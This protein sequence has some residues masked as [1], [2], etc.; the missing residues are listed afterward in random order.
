MPAF[1]SA[2]APRTSNNGIFDVP[3]G[4][5]SGS[6]LGMGSPLSPDVGLHV[7]KHSTGRRTEAQRAREH[8]RIRQ[9]EQT[10][11]PP[12]FQAGC[13]S[14][15]DE[16]SKRAQK[17]Q[18]QHAQEQDQDQDQGEQDQDTGSTTLTET[19]SS[20]ATP[21]ELDSE[22][23]TAL[24]TPLNIRSS[25]SGPAAETSS[26]ASPFETENHI[27][28][29]SRGNTSSLPWTPQRAPRTK[30]ITGSQTTS[31]TQDD[32]DYVY[33]D[34]TQPKLH[35]KYHSPSTPIHTAPTSG[36]VTT[37]S[38]SG[39][40]R[41]RPRS[42]KRRRRRLHPV[43]YRLFPVQDYFLAEGRYCDVYL[44]SYLPPMRP[45]SSSHFSLD[46]SHGHLHP[47]MVEVAP[48]GGTGMNG[49]TNPTH[50]FTAETA[51]AQHFPEG[52]HSP[53]PPSP[54]EWRLCAVKRLHA[55]TTSQLVGLDEAYAL[56]RLGKHPGIVQLIDI[57]D[58]MLTSPQAP[59]Q[60]PSA[61]STPGRLVSLN[62]DAS[63]EANEAA[64]QHHRK[65]EH[66]DFPGKP[67][68]HIKPD[69]HFP[70]P[71]KADSPR[72]L[73]LLELLP[74]SLGSYVNAHPQAVDLTQWL[75]WAIQLSAA[76][77]YM[78]S[79]GAIHGDI[80]LDNCLLTR[81]L[82]LK[83]CDF[84]S[85][86]WIDP[87]NLPTDGA[88]LGTP[89]YSAPELTSSPWGM[90]GGW[91][92]T[93]SLSSS[94]SGSGYGEGQQAQRGGFGLPV[95]VWAMG[96]CLYSL[97]S[98]RAPFARATSM[99]DML[100]RK[101]LFWQAEECDRMRRL[102][103][104]QGL[105][106][107]EQERLSSS[108]ASRASGR[109]AVGS[110]GWTTA[111]TSTPTRPVSASRTPSLC[112]R[113]EGEHLRTPSHHTRSP[114][115]VSS[116]SGVHAGV[117]LS[118]DQ[119]LLEH[120]TVTHGRVPRPEAVSAL[121]NPAPPPVRKPLVAACST[122]AAVSPISHGLATP[123]KDASDLAQP[124]TTPS[125]S[126]PPH[127]SGLGL[128]LG[129][130]GSGGQ[131]GSGPVQ[132]PGRAVSMRAPPGHPATRV[133]H[134]NP[135]A[136]HALGLGLGMAGVDP[137]GAGASKARS[138]G[139]SRI[140]TQ[141][142]SSGRS[143]RRNLSARAA[144]QGTAPTS[145]DAVLSPLSPESLD[146][147]SPGVLPLS[148]GWVGGPRSESQKMP[149]AIMSQVPHQRPP[150]NQ[151]HGHFNADPHPHPYRQLETREAHVL[152]SSPGDNPVDGVGQGHDGEGRG[153]E[154][155]ENGEGEHEGVPAHAAG[156]AVG[157]VATDSL[158]AYKDGMPAL[159]LPG[160]GRWPDE[161][162]DLVRSMVQVDPL[163]RPTCQQVLERLCMLR[164]RLGQT[165]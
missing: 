41:M 89:A 25:H 137:S 62:P 46:Q 21:D 158:P 43:S 51:H 86:L 163:L 151:S 139:L 66:S 71:D 49:A 77:G 128:G 162:R 160:G 90:G 39:S 161:A 119:D 148:A 121:L 75:E 31:Q 123:P 135:N 115:S 102:T 144:A 127:A 20:E 95:D 56:R 114:A 44:G 74:H 109:G 36:S 96:V 7:R 165:I 97:A 101:P 154:G 83:L 42:I 117:Y 50:L 22:P 76:V 32:A 104:D 142:Y 14:L 110:A 6:S 29:R 138:M 78:H 164:D 118:P 112:H 150:Q 156:D 91:G 159:I 152:P 81:D 133:P 87:N 126:V 129:L 155:R 1:G 120:M 16:R 100:H 116:S 157:S 122:E 47:G 141:L 59:P 124:N 19:E 70:P 2:P 108:R 73:I 145:V 34:P 132:L 53:A 153:T 26:H 55:D 30:G 35:A 143:A 5:G 52:Q 17:Q 146:S 105:H 67:D 93:P 99:V 136:G 24:D 40:L 130:A 11:P 106:E 140:Q 69:A 54:C 23:Q 61:S 8:A 92:H 37:N 10:F 65:L 38:P 12:L 98:G 63:H 94:H 72:L 131:A 13:V 18:E 48:G 147:C 113:A 79:R 103:L 3:Q 64:V 57:V 85:T 68:Q 82:R 15:S 149:G 9:R 33:Q 60:A 80:K 58:E 45:G 107:L 134:Q 125:S 111:A 84:N 4:L 28:P 88:G 27:E